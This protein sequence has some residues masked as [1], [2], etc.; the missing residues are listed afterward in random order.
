MPD[1]LFLCQEKEHVWLVS[2]RKSEEVGKLERWTN[3]KLVFDVYV[4]PADI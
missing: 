2:R 1:E 4:R 3:A